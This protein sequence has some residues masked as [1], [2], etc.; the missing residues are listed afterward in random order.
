MCLYVS[1]RPYVAMYGAGTLTRERDQRATT[2]SLYA[3]HPC[4]SQFV[5]PEGAIQAV[6]LCHTLLVQEMWRKPVFLYAVIYPAEPLLYNG[7][8][9]VITKARKLYSISPIHFLLHKLNFQLDISQ[10]RRRPK[11]IQ[12]FLKVPITSSLF[13]RRRVHYSRLKWKARRIHGVFSR[14]YK[15]VH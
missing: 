3:K 2:L 1:C 12:K 4:H 15:Y 14:S 13:R 10:G 6:R 11:F 9:S 8:N 7:P 5:W